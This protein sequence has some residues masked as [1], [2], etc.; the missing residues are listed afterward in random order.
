MCRKALQLTRAI[1]KGTES[2]HNEPIIKESKRN[3][4]NATTITVSQTEKSQP[5][6][7]DRLRHD[8]I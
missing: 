1:D 6:L 5:Q 4:P 3:E 7:T 2:K 8:V